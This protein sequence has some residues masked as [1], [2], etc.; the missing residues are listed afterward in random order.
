MSAIKGRTKRRDNAVTVLLQTRVTTTVRDAMHA[1][2]EESGLSLALYIEALVQQQLEDHGSLPV[3][4]HLAR[5][6]WEELP[7]PAA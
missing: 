4:D 7:I 6:R 3:F 5:P 1:A 2:A